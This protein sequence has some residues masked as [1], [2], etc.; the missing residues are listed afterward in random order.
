[1]YTRHKDQLFDSD[2]WNK[3]KAY[4]PKFAK[5]DCKSSDEQKINIQMDEEEKQ[6]QIRVARLV[7][8]FFSLFAKLKKLLIF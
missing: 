7:E 2:L 6:R 3:I 8:F 5:S 1:M 4:Y